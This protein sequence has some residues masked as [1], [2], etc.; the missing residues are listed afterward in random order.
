[1]ANELNYPW[2]ETGPTPEELWRQRPTLSESQR[3][4]FLALVQT[5]QTRART[6]LGYPLHY[7]LDFHAQATID[8]LAI[9]C[10]LVEFG[11]LT[12]TRR[13]FTP[14]LPPPKLV[15]IS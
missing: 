9:R 7:H 1:M 2:S 6:E 8:R 12:L 11:F 10:A 5:Q 14:P 3:A 15:N 4:D 13:Y